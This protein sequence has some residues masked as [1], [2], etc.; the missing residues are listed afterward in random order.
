MLRE[1]AGEYLARKIVIQDDYNF[2]ILPKLVKF[3]KKDYCPGLLLEKGEGG[4]E[5]D[6][7]KLNEDIKLMKALSNL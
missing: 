5:E 1:N 6:V 7:L 3:F 4:E 2:I